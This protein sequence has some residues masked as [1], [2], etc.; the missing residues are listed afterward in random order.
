MSIEAAG[1]ATQLASQKIAFTQSQIKQNV[2]QERQVADILTQ[3]ADS[4][5]QAATSNGRGGNVNIVV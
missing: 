3:A 4:A 2:Q 1:V 5:Q